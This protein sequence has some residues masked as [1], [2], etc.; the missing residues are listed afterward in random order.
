MLSYIFRLICLCQFKANIFMVFTKKS[1]KIHTRMG[2]NVIEF[3]FNFC[4]LQ[5]T[6]KSLLK[7]WSN[8]WTK[9]DFVKVYMKWISFYSWDLVKFQLTFHLLK[10]FS[11]FSWEFLYNIL[12]ILISHLIIMRFQC[13]LSLFN[14]QYLSLNVKVLYQYIKFISIK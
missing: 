7:F 10:S 13:Q 2:E 9:N 12:S 3:W 11:K 6:K 1:V 14:F 8:I 5:Q 4:Q